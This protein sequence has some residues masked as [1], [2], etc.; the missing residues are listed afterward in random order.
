MRKFIVTVLCILALAVICTTFLPTER[1]FNVVAAE[2]ITDGTA[3]QGEDEA[4]GSVVLPVI[5]YHQIMKHPPR[6]SRYIVTPAQFEADI[7][8]LKNRGYNAVFPSEV[9]DFVDGRGSL[10]QKPIIITFDD[11]HYNDVYYGEP[12]LKKYGFKAV[13][14]VIGKFAERSY[15][16]GDDS[17]PA[18]SNLSW[19]QIKDID[20]NVFEIGNHTYDLHN[21]KPR[22]G[23]AR[24]SGESFTAYHNAI[25]NDIGKLQETLKERCNTIPIC[26]AYP[27]GKYNMRA[28]TWLSQELGFKVIFNCREKNNI[29]SRGSGEALLDLNRYNRESKYTTAE[30]CD[31][32]EGK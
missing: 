11:G 18:Y 29:I 13:L 5:M 20:R 14:N 22:Y 2:E 1:R 15:K 32:I 3:E 31:K 23:I 21:I 8:E 12:I 27:F 24:L 17:N 28:K 6:K 10:P 9:V 16:S 26:F 7:K 4:G 19:T 30:F 25:S